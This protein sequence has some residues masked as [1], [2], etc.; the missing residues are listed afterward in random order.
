MNTESMLKKLE[1]EIFRIAQT[2][3]NIFNASEIR[4]LK[5][6]LTAF[7]S[8]RLGHLLKAYKELLQVGRY[9]P[10]QYNKGNNNDGKK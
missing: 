10:L 8:I 6:R 7:E 5:Q 2:E 1:Q 3:F 4:K 9:T